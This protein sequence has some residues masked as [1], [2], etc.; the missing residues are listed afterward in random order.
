MN[1]TI[2]I[3][4]DEED[5]LDLL[6][7]NLQK[8][9]YE[10]ITCKDTKNVRDILDEEDISLIIMD[11]NLP[12]VEGSEF[13]L[14]LRKEGYDQP[15]I[16]LSAKERSEEI[17][18]GFERGGDDYITKP[19]DLNILKARIKAL[20]KRLSKELSSSIKEGDIL[21]DPTKKSF[22]IDDKELS[23]TKLEH[24][25]LLTLLRYKNQLLSREFLLEE[26]WEDAINKQP[27]TVN[28]AI[29]RLKEKIDPTG[30]RGYISSVRGEGY[31]FSTKGR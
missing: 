3:V 14:Q 30:K 20:L 24:D 4:D 19:F 29:K 22:Y 5:I 9:G 23:L 7:Y 12:G 25:L 28:V 13:I 15:V 27:K 21:Y 11:R 26:V 18:E 10:V 17:V 6:E 2:L 8:E 31:I 16:Y 1:K